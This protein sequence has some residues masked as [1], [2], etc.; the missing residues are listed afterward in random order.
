MKKRLLAR[1]TVASAMYLLLIW[2]FS[3]L[4]DYPQFREQQQKLRKHDLIA[5][6]RPWLNLFY[7]V[8]EAGS[9]LKFILTGDEKHMQHFPSPSHI[10]AARQARAAS[11][12][13]RARLQLSRMYYFGEYAPQDH[14]MAL[15]WLRAAHEAAAPERRGEIQELITVIFDG[16]DHGEIGYKKNLRARKFP[17]E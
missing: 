14:E 4:H 13:W 10:L 1:L 7:F 17:P 8:N 15:Y 2:V 5:Q 6:E 3:S 16:D 9:G 12:D 11:G